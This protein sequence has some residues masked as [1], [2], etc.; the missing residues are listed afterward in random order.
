MVL[1]EAPIEEVE[2][3]LSA[4]DIPI[5]VA[6]VLSLQKEEMV[7]DVPLVLT[8]AQE[9]IPPSIRAKDVLSIPM[10]E[11]LKDVHLLVAVSVLVEEMV[12][13]VPPTES[14]LV[15]E[16]EEI[17]LERILVHL[18]IRSLQDAATLIP[19]TEPQETTLRINHG[20][21]Q[22]FFSGRNSSL[23]Q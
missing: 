23:H 3:P 7:K 11:S 4:A 12:S 10:T 20:E 6:S 5:V 1:E 9:D 14:S 17:S 21:K 2:S 16:K 19:D 15:T 13:P 8:E 22:R 18:L